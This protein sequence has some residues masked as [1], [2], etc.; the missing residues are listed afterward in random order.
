VVIWDLSTHS[1]L[2]DTTKRTLRAHRE[3]AVVT[4]FGQL[5]LQGFDPFLVSGDRRSL[6]PNL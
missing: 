4:V 1:P 3:T 5:A 2:Q 6:L